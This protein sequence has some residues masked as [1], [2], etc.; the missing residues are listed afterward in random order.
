M[1]REMIQ[2]NIKKDSQKLRAVHT[3]L[4]D[5]RDTWKEAIIIA[6]NESQSAANASHSNY[7]PLKASL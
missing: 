5:L 4:S 2:A 6:R 7:Q 1:I 3:M